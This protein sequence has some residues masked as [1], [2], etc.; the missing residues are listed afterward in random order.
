M[1]DEIKDNDYWINKNN[2]I[3]SKR[4]ADS[5]EVIKSNHN[6]IQSVKSNGSANIN[7]LPN[8]EYCKVLF[9]KIKARRK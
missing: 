7:M 9:D 5:K 6:L 2:E 1:S 4:L 3:R 8:N